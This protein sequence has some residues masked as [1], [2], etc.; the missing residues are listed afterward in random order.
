MKTTTLLALLVSAAPIAAQAESITGGMTLSYTRHSNDF[1]D[2]RTTGLDGRL[3]ID[4]DN[5]LR[6][7]FDLGRSTMS[8]DGSPIDLDAEFYSVEASYGFGGGM[9]AGLFADRLSIGAGLS[10]I[11]VTLSTNGLSF[12]YEGNGFEGEAFVGKTSLNV[13]LP[14]EIK[15][16]G[17][18]GHYTGMDKLDVGAAFL[19]AHL[20]QGGNST[21]MDFR[22]VAATYL[23]TPQLMVFGGFGQLDLG[24]LSSAGIDSFGL[25]VSYDLGAKMGFSSSVSLEVGRVSQGGSDADVLRVGWTIPLGKSGPALPMNSVA[26]AVLN[27]RH[28]AFNAG[29]TAGF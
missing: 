18:F 25:G 16:Y 20:T 10:P 27:P 2:M 22:G 26:D 4:M 15:N 8:Q 12:G 3:A 13:P 1:G 9:R 5:G 11:D 6:F 24:L 29:V 21:N 14:F 19:R 28:G 17:V 7:G 23:A